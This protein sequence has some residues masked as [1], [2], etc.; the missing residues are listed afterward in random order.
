M[1]AEK[2]VLMERIITRTWRPS[3][4]KATPAPG[5]APPP[6]H[7]DIDKGWEMVLMTT[8]LPL[9]GTAVQAQLES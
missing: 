5:P 3:Q 4:G 7:R 2:F 6:P 8:V 1:L 9:W